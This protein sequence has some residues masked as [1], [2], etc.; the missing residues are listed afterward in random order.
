MTPFD[1]DPLLQHDPHPGH[2]IVLLLD[3]H[4]ELKNHQ[5]SQL[6]PV[7]LLSPDVGYLL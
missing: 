4:Q 7:A 6:L 3:N 1:P 2:Y 5:T